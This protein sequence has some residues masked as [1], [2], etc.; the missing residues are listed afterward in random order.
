MIRTARIIANGFLGD[1]VVLI[2]STARVLAV[3]DAGFAVLFTIRTTATATMGLHL[4]R[5]DVLLLM[6]FPTAVTFSIAGTR[7]GAGVVVLGIVSTGH[8]H[9]TGGSGGGSREEEGCPTDPSII[10]QKRLS[11]HSLDYVNARQVLW[12]IQRFKWGRM[13]VGGL[14][15]I[16]YLY[17]LYHSALCELESIPTPSSGDLQLESIPRSIHQDFTD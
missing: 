3:V 16:G 1:A 12:R 17:H 4:A 11:I 13:A 15:I 2:V 6:I 5:D 7:H 8:G 14:S 9:P 10:V